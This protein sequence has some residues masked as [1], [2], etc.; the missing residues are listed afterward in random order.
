MHIT[1]LITTPALKTP[2]HSLIHD[3]MGR[4]L[5]VSLLSL[6]GLGV[7][8]VILR[9]PGMGQYRGLTAPTDRHIRHHSSQ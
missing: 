8:P 6:S 4:G 2:Y 9:G 1:T 7:E 3:S 5:A